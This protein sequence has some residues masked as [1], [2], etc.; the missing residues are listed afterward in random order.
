MTTL[1][2]AGALVLGAAPADT[3]PKGFLLWEKAAAKKDNDPETNWAVNR[4]ATAKLTVNP[5][6]KSALASAGRVAARTIVYTA[7]PDFQKSEQVIL[8]AT[9]DQATQALAELRAALR[10]CG[11][12]KT[13]GSEYRY[14]GKAVKLGDEGLAVTGQSYAG[15]KPAIGGERA[16]VSRRGTA[17]VLYSQA[18]EWGKPAAADFA[19]QTKDAKKMLGKICAIA[20]C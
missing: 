4:R 20:S 15:R 8:Y 19:A 10:A 16:I 17:L 9:K 2:L 5:C 14:S 18:G 3:I 11:S 13:E 12:I 6:D 7:V 1:L